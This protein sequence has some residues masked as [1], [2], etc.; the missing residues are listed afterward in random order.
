M[1]LEKGWG[2]KWACH[3]YCPS[4]RVTV[5]D[6]NDRTAPGKGSSSLRAMSCD[7]VMLSYRVGKCCNRLNCGS[8]PF[9]SLLKTSSGTL[10]PLSHQFHVTPCGYPCL[11]HHRRTKVEGREELG[12]EMGR[13]VGHRELREEVDVR[14]GYNWGGVL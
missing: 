12:R 2:R 7:Y 14:E 6:P 11:S 3:V 13:Q 9:V 8:N 1:G 5:F 4:P 10:C